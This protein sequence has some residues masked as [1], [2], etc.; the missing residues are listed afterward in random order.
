MSTRTV[1]ASDVEELRRIRANPA[2]SVLAP[3]DRRRPGNAEDPLR[4]RHLVDQACARVAAEYPEPLAG[5]V[6]ERLRDA[7]ASIDFDDP[8]D[9]V[10]LFATPTGARVYG[11]AFAVPE[12]VVVDETLATRDLVR[13]L[14]RSP[15]YRVLVLSEHH[16]R[17]F[18]GIFDRLD[19]ARTGGFPLAAAGARG[20]PLAS[21]GYA[22]H[23]DRSDDQHRQFFREVDTALGRTIGQDRTPLFIVGVERDLAFFDEVTRHEDVVAGRLQAGHERTRPGE[24]ADAVR[25]LVDEYIASRRAQAIDTLVEAV[26]AGQ[27]VVGVKA[28]WQAARE[29]RGRLLVVENGYTYPAHV[30]GDRLEPADREELGAVDDAVDEVVETVLARDGEVVFAGAGSL[31]EHGPIALVTGY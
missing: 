14:Q 9:G 22:T 4:L 18:D 26:G 8:T 11:L 23:T 20:E 28:V 29:G 19:E 10:A 13:G 7:F 16:T 2:V 25:P 17:L 30:V 24:L 6:T 31:G 21:G 27:A 5:T 3:T 12:R 1:Q 15:R